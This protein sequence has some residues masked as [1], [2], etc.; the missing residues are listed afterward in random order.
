[1]QPAF[2]FS[3]SMWN[4]CVYNCAERDFCVLMQPTNVYDHTNFV[5]LCSTSNF[6]SKFAMKH[7]DYVWPRVISQ[8]F[9]LRILKVIIQL[10]QASKGQP[11][12]DFGNQSRTTNSYRWRSGGK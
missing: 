3:A 12:T 8:A 5:I 4:Q 2:N 7:F 9:F 10:Q 1:M 6:L 11:I